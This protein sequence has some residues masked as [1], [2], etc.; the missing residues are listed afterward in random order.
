MMETLFD[1]PCP[2]CN[3]TGRYWDPRIGT[4]RMCDCRAIQMPSPDVNPEAPAGIESESDI[5]RL[6]KQQARV[7]AIMRDGLWHTLA[8][9]SHRTGDPE[10]SIS[11][12]F[13]DLRKRK[14]GG[15]TIERELIGDGLFRYRLRVNPKARML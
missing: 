12:R 14:Y 5:I 10:A 13:R 3:D 1:L 11:A 6:N 4:D 2:K 7:W 9:M 15:H 8:E